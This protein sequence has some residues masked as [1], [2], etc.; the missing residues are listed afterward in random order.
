MCVYVYVCVRVSETLIESL[1]P[2]ADDLARHQRPA[3]TNRAFLDE[4]GALQD[5]QRTTLCRAMR[6]RP[7]LLNLT[8]VPPNLEQKLKLFT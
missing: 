2:V 4:G 7:R 1:I 6:G 3:L 8:E 5:A